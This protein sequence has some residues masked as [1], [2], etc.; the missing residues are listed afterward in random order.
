MGNLNTIHAAAPIKS[1]VESATV[2][3]SITA[4]A[5][6]SQ[7]KEQNAP[8]SSPSK[9]PGV[10]EDLHKKCKELQPGNFDGFRLMVNKGLSNNFQVSHTL[11]LSSAPQ[12]TSYHFGAT[13]VG[14]SQSNPAEATP[15]IL[16]DIDNSGSLSAQ[17]IHQFNKRI[18]GKCVVQTQQKEFA[19]V[20]ADVDY[21]GDD[22]TTTCTLGNIDILNESGIIVAH[23]LQRVTDNIDIGTE[24]LYHYGQG[25]QSAILSLAGR[26]S[27]DKWVAA[28]QINA[29]GWHASYY[30]KGND[31]VQVGVDYEYNSRMQ[32]SNVSLGYQIDIPKA[33]VTFRGMV[34]T[35]WAV[36]GLF[37]KKLYPL[38]FSFI[39]SGKLDH[40]KNQSRFGFGLQIG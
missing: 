31:N 8:S 2:A 19:M 24:L 29:G 9:N 6:S 4:P 12:L 16:G 26:Y 37:E 38:P 10:F 25:Q 11:N 40:L 17:I 14:G 1:T 28:A 20:Q 22:F 35:N 27:A 34:D 33:N 7:Q 23:Y 21:R 18:K 3:P 5:P 15:V 39:L 13:Y 30:R 32:D 36:G